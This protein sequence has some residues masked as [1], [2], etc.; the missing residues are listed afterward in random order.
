MSKFRG[1]NFIKEGRI[2]TSSFVTLTAL[3]RNDGIVPQENKLTNNKTTLIEELSH[4]Q[5]IQLIFE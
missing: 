1:R 3:L 2:V 5:E 4:K